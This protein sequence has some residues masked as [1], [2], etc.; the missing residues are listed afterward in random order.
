MLLNYMSFYKSCRLL[1]E[2]LILIC[3]CVC[4][5]GEYF[6]AIYS[7]FLQFNNKQLDFMFKIREIA[8]ITPLFNIR[9]G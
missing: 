3:T 7:I 6:K 4:D 9:V 5:V 2:N 1:K 8:H